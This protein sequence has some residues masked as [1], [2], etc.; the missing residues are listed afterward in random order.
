MDEKDPIIQYVVLR[1]D[2]FDKPYNWPFGSVTTQACHACVGAIA[3]NLEDKETQTYICKEYLNDMHKVVL[4]VENEKDLLMIAKDLSD[5]NVKFKLWKE[6]P[7]MM[8]TC[9]ATKPYT[10]STI[11]KFFKTL[12]LFKV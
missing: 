8:N 1:K 10:K 2:L 9:L 5:N 3:E 4:K 7:E 12:K 6:K 11:S